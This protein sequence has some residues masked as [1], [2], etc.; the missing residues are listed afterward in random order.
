MKV[1]RKIKAVFCLFG[2][3]AFLA[4]CKAAQMVEEP[5]QKAITIQEKKQPEEKTV[6]IAEPKIVFGSKVHNF[7]N[8]GIK[9]KAE[10]EFRF[11]NAGQAPLK[12]GKIKS[13]CGCTVPSLS[14]KEYEPSEKGVIKI[15][16]SG[17]NKPGSV[18]KHIYVS[19]SDKKN[20]KVKLT[21]KAKVIHLI[22]VAPQKLQLSWN[23]KNAGM[24]VITIKSEDG[25]GFSI[26]G[27]SASKDV[28]KAEFDPN[29]VASKFVL[30]P[31]IDLQKLKKFRSGSIR[32]NLTHPKCSYVTIPYEVPS[33]FQCQP[34]RIVLHNI[35]PNKP[36][37]KELLIK[38]TEKKQ[39]EIESISSRRGYIKAISQQ[40][41]N[42]K[43]KLKLQVTPPPT[44]AKVSHFSDDL[45]IKIKN[46]EKLTIACSGF[47]ARKS[48]KDKTTQ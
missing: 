18:A 14:K 47:Y 21:I 6:K 3:L 4:E 32:I 23:K 36:Q 1:D 7:G 8:L 16:Y 9:E 34:S 11:K 2:A 41:D 15:K 45:F 48:V 12:I 28:I 13:T 24:T 33:K 31:K 46:D 35:M 30:K 19:T 25:K 38:N 10:C 29:A 43:I 26:K 39:F 5:E 20:S 37:I 40:P 22:E 42:D 17:Q 44:R 27:F